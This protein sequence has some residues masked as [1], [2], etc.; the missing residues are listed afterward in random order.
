MRDF[1]IIIT[2]G[3]VVLFFIIGVCYI[4]WGDI[5]NEDNLKPLWVII[6]TM[7]AVLWYLIY[8]VNKKP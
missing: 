2:A 1:S 7:G 6:P 3:L 5:T 8:K 4:I